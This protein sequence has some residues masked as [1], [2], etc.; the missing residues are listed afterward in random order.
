M[1]YQLEDEAVI[2]AIDTTT[3]KLVVL[4]DEVNSFDFVIETL[5]KVCKHTAEQAEQCTM[6][7]HYKGKCV[8]K[9]GDYETLASMCTAITDRGIGA[10]ISN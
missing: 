4:N 3:Y 7:I 8:V 2:E 10:E 5:I 6:I 9:V 1:S